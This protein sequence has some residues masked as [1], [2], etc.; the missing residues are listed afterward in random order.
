MLE[1]YSCMQVMLV[2][3]LSQIK[4]TSSQVGWLM[5]VPLYTETLLPPPS[6]F[7]GRGQQVTAMHLHKPS[8]VLTPLPFRFTFQ[9][10]TWVFQNN[11]GEQSL[12]TFVVIVIVVICFVILL[13]FALFLLLLLA[14]PNTRDVL[15]NKFIALMILDKSYYPIDFLHSCS[16]LYAQSFILELF[17]KIITC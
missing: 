11:N 13:L 16:C 7:C 1:H 4:G 9:Y 3:A 2:T 10:T 8:Y 17:K 12:F 14:Y 5:T 15:Y 6:R